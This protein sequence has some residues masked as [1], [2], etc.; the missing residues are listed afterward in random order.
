MRHFSF[1]QS[2]KSIVL[3]C[4][5]LFFFDSEAISLIDTSKNKTT[6]ID[7]FGNYEYLHGGLKFQCFDDYYLEL[8]IGI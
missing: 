2:F 5:F 6:I 7:G 3:V 1:F 4:F 8:A